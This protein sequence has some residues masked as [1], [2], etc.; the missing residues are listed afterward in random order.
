LDPQFNA[1]A[2]IEVSVLNNHIVIS[3]VANSVMD[4]YRPVVVSLASANSRMQ[5]R[6]SSR[7]PGHHLLLKV[8]AHS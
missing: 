5:S 6:R 2:D 8:N 1:A 7:F 3:E 4:K